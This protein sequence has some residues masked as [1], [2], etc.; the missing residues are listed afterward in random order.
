MHLKKQIFSLEN[1]ILFLK[2]EMEKKSSHFYFDSNAIRHKQSL[3]KELNPDCKELNE[4]SMTEY[5]KTVHSTGI[6]KRTQIYYLVA[7]LKIQ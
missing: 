6:N 4:K 1:E 2:K 3:H 5:M 7:Q